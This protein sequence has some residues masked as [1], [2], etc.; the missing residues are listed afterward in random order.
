[1]IY[2]ECPLCGGCFLV[3]WGD[4]AANPGPFYAVACS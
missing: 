1:M 3:F 2:V 4:A